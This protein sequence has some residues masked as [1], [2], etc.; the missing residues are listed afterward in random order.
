MKTYQVSGIA[1][2]ANDGNGPLVLMLHGIGG[3]SDVFAAL[4]AALEPSYRALAWDAPGYG[5][6][7]DPV[8]APEMSGYASAAAGVLTGQGIAEPARRAAHV[9]GVSW[10][11]VIATRLALEYPQLV[12]SLTL[13]DSTRGSGRTPDGAAAMRARADELESLGAA[14]F[15]RR[16]AARLVSDAAAQSIVDGVSSVMAA[17]RL[18]G[19]R[20]A[21]ESMAQTDHSGRLADIAV[22]TQ[23]LV[24]AQDRVTGPAE[25]ERLADGIPGA[26]LHVI[27]DAGHAANQENPAEFNRL[28]LGF[29]SMVDSASPMPRGV[30]Q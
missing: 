15:A 28:V 29:F 2:A 11:G 21:A 1:V 25:S 8:A 12:R 14:E 5:A 27:P 10:G 18:P 19:Y 20:F 23:V 9:V 13:A 24:G 16:R 22:P 3:A 26:R 7:P 4:L 6:S 17:V 30:R